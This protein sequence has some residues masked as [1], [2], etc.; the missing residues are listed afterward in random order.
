MNPAAVVVAVGC[1]AQVAG[2]ELLSDEAIDIV[3]GNNKKSHLADIL[4]E[5]YRNN[6]KSKTKITIYEDLSEGC[7]YEKMQMTTVNDHTRAFIK[8]QDG[9]NQFCTYCIIPYS[10]GRVRSR[11][12]TDI[13]NE[14]YKL[15]EKGYKEIVLTGIHLS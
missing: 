6:K 13:V 1:Y 14:V 2:E 7:K 8:I 9:C 15:A 12:I 10:R 3:I 4:E 5:Y 11:S